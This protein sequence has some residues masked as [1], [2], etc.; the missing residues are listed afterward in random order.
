MKLTASNKGLQQIRCARSR[1]DHHKYQV[2]N[3]SSISHFYQSMIDLREQQLYGFFYG[4]LWEVIKMIIVIL[5]TTNTPK[6]FLKLG[7]ENK[8]WTLKWRT[9]IELVKK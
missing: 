2:Y 7:L 4:R 6:I 9:F 3:D 8:L 1:H 5:N